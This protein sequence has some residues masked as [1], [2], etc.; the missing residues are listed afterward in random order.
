[1]SGVRLCFVVSEVVRKHA[2]TDRNNY[3]ADSDADTVHSSSM[4]NSRTFTP[5]DDGASERPPDSPRKLSVTEDSHIPLDGGKEL[6]RF[7]Q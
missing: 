7:A 2:L 1:M 4:Q 3:A 5:G 6:G